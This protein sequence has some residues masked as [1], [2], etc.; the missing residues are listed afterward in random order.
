MA[1]S[2]SYALAQKTG[3]RPRPRHNPRKYLRVANVQRDHID[4]SDLLE[5]EAS[6]TEME[7]MALQA[8]DLL[9]VEG[10]ANPEE[11]G[12]CALVDAASSGLTFQ[13]H[14]FRLRA[15]KMLAEFANAWMNSQGTRAYWRR[16]CGTSSGL[17]TINRTM[18]KAV[19]VPV[20]QHNEQHRIVAAF[21]QAA[22]RIN[23]EEVY[24]DKLKLQKRGLRHDLLTGRVRV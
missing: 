2:L 16:M 17:N 20:P 14:L 19:L 11:I 10:H 21:S 18:L 15:R 4:L 6:A 12:R 9:V 5:L 23:A 22:A 24:C 8:G 7:G 3:G 13:N 1:P